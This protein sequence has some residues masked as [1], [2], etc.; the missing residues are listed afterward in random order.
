MFNASRLIACRLH[1]VQ[2]TS[3]RTTI[4]QSACS[5]LVLCNHFYG[6]S[7]KF[8]HIHRVIP[9]KNTN[10]N[11]NRQESDEKFTRTGNAENILDA[12]VIVKVSVTFIDLAQNWT[13][14][15]KSNF[16]LIL[17]FR[18]LT[19]D[20]QRNNI[21]IFRQKSVKADHEESHCRSLRSV[22]W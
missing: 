16:D 11:I 5:L 18:S 15:R 10:L 3:C 2:F 21:S 1:D 8:Y 7:F 19:R 22:N 9:L 17:T 4:V 13:I 6:Y 14:Q 12:N 20:L